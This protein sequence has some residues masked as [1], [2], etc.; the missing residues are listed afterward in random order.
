MNDFEDRPPGDGE[1]VPPQARASGRSRIYQARRDQYIA[2]RDL[3]VHYTDGVR[4]SR[5]STTVA[6][7]TADEC[8]YP[9]L[10]SF[11]AE[12][13]RWFFGRDTVTAS[14]LVRLDELMATGGP[15]MVVAPS[16]AGKSSVLRA[17]LLPALARGAL[18]AAGSEDW[19][20]LLFT[21]GT[22]PCTVLA[23]QLAHGSGVGPQ[24]MTEAL[25]ADPQACMDL[26]RT[27][28]RAP[29][30]G[31]GR[32]DRRLVVVVD[33]LEEL[34]SECEDEQE[35]RDFV[36]VLDALA[37]PATPGTGPTALVI[38]GL[39]S[40][41][42]TPCAGHPWLRTAL[43]DRQILVG[44]MTETE[45]REA[46]L[47][48]ARTEGLD[49]E[50][51]L[52]ELLL[53]DLGAPPGAGPPGAYEAGRLPLLAHALRAT[54]QRRD[55]HTLTVDGYRDTGGIGRA[56]AATAERLYTGL[57][58]PAQHS[59]RAVF[60]RLVKIGDGIEDTRRRLP[61]A[62][63]RNACGAPESCDRIVGTFTRSRLL[64]RHQDTVEIT[65]EAL[66]HAWPRLRQW[67]GEDRAGHLIHQD[68]EEAAAGWDVARRDSTMLYR[69]ARLE[70]V[71]TWAVRSQQSPTSSTAS[72]FLKAATRQERRGTRVRRTIIAV[73]ASLSLVASA[74]AVFAFQQR[75]DAQGQ[76][77]NVIFNR[78]TSEAERLYDSQSSVAARF[79]L[80]A[81]RLRADDQDVRTRL[82]ADA[83]GP[84]SMPLHG[85]KGSVNAVAFS[86]DGKTLAS[87]GNDGTVRLWKSASSGIPPLPLGRPLQH[88]STVDSMAFSLDGR[89]LVAAGIGG[90]VRQW[91]VTTPARPR[92]LRQVMG[93]S[94]VIASVALSPDGRT[95]AIA[96]FTGPLQLW[97][98]NDP[99]HRGPLGKPLATTVHTVAFS[100]DGHVLAAA[101]R[102]GLRLWNVRDPA[103]PTPLGKPLKAVANTM[104][105]SPDGNTLATAGNDNTLSLWSLADD[106]PQ[107]RLL[108]GPLADNTSAIRSM[109]F[110]PDGHTLATA[111]GDTV[112]LW[113]LTDPYDPTS[114]GKPLAGH[115]EGVRSV[116]FSPDG[117]TLASAGGGGTTLLWNLPRTIVTSA[118]DP[119]AFGP[120]AS[121][122]ATAGEHGELRLWKTAD[123]AGP[124]PLG[125]PTVDHTGEIHSVAFSP[126]RRT[127]ATGADRAVRLWNVADPARPAP[128]GA[129]L[130]TGQAN[131][132]SLAFSPDGRV[133]AGGGQDHTVRLWDVADPVR[134]RQLGTPLTGHAAPV[135]SVAFSPDGH[136]LASAGDDRTVRLWKVADPA[137][138]TAL[139]A[140]LKATAHALA[141]SP[142]GQTLAA[143]GGAAVQ[144][145]SLAGADR[146]TI[147]SPPLAVGDD[148]LHALAFSPTGGTLAAGGSGAVVRLWNLGDRARPTPQGEPLTGHTSTIQSLA[149][150]PDGHTLASGGIDVRL[151][152]LD[153]DR[154]ARRVCDAT[155]GT[156][157]RGEWQLHFPEIPFTAPCT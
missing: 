127:L 6:A 1:G 76:R 52:V 21:P 92:P 90:A 65:H 59:A 34:F 126:D 73:L 3:H 60:L 124:T 131:M 155:A 89:T 29:G 18:P 23:E 109:A 80:V 36:G 7:S 150:S 97:K 103:R 8:P 122:L 32:P 106:A 66:L 33:Q 57:D 93:H 111:G 9:G 5:R 24:Q 87:A 47:F 67:L 105:F 69:G 77:D 135:H 102:G 51:G 53:R 28:L 120:D 2:E 139:G 148:D 104:V 117:H 27:A 96:D 38:C 83:N 68:L 42:Y 75:A 140:P 85:H 152:E 79:D 78:I 54:W 45:L 82:I 133:L 26:L 151:W 4:R 119:L 91:N 123:S 118:H 74:A 13:V 156:L 50:P 107:P 11:G 157:T 12:Q 115:T 72:E 142:D 112:R 86:P 116:A 100:P 95:V 125:R 138:P 19:P 56:V 128:L 137:R 39:R 43:Q 154:A 15:L 147:L 30:A 71:R 17:G 143:A 61:F 132:W 136:T 35:Q 58:P 110:S 49:I 63:L 94:A 64:T 10:A 25:A 98:L 81:H 31:P 84:L 146:P 48:P 108:G 44:P 121:T 113:N 153:V 55:G 20:R 145:W 130:I 88:D 14:I 114:L 40:D 144:L 141:F 41:F 46:V 149:F 16:G 22:R 99:A 37:R 134:P 129:E 70:A 62:V 101:D